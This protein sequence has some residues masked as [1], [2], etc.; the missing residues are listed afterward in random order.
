MWDSM[1]DLD[2]SVAEKVLR[3]ALL[4]GFLVVALRLSGKRLMAQLTT[5]DFIVLLLVSN[6]VQNGLIG[7]DV[8]ITGAVISTIVLF[9]LNGGL[10][11]LFFR[12]RKAKRLIAG[13]PSLLIRDGEVD[14][15][16]LRHQRFSD[17]DLMVALQDAG[18]SGPGQVHEAR[19]EAN[20]QL[21]VTPRADDG[22]TTTELMAA[23]RELGARLDRLSPPR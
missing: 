4:Y 15:R 2:L 19:L 23:I 13:E 16:A 7:N 14:E 3:A 11:Y 21:L 17:D 22:P 9:A 12:S 18:A 20:G 8:S 5:F 1:F 10:A 6:T